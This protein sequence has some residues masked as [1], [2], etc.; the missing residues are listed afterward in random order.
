MDSVLSVV[1]FAGSIGV[2]G[3]ARP[4]AAAVSYIRQLSV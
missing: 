3:Y 4:E 1:L 2:M